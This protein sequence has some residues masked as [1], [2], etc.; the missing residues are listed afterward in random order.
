MALKEKLSKNAYF[1]YYFILMQGIGSAI[2]S[3]GIEFAIA[4]GMYHGRRR[5]KMWRFPHTMAGDLVVSLW[6]QVGLTWVLE[7]IFIGW[8]FCCG[9][10]CEFPHMDAICNYVKKK[11]ALYWY[12][13]VEYGM[14]PR[15]RGPQGF[16]QY[17]KDLFLPERNMSRGH[18]KKYKLWLWLVR[19]AMRCLS[20]GLLLFIFFWPTTLGIMV[21]PGT[22][23]GRH[24][25]SYNSYPFPQ[26]MKLIFGFVLGLICT[27]FTVAVV[28]IR[29][30]TYTRMVDSGELEEEW[31]SE[32]G[33]EGSPE[34]RKQDQL[35]MPS[36]SASVE[37]KC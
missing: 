2:I 32:A 10:A 31:P 4:Y 34:E 29:N 28:I 26:V 12:C 16:K 14:L 20:W 25:Y 30:E 22:K 18:T 36:E 35:L 15:E 23:Y 8:D 27:P 17:L 9:S 24:D 19:K 33:F 13:E 1:F 3:G 7:E 5:V 6:V 11:K 37:S 21:A